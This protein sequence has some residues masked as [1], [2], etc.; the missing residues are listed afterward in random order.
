M[1]TTVDWR[2]RAGAI[3][4]LGV[5]VDG[6][7]P[8][9]QAVARPRRRQSV[10]ADGNVSTAAASSLPRRHSHVG[11]STRCRRPGGTGSVTQSE[12][13]LRRHPG[14][15]AQE[16][17][18]QVKGISRRT[19]STATTIRTGSAGLLLAH[20]DNWIIS[21]GTIIGVLGGHH[22][23]GDPKKDGD[24]SFATR[25]DKDFEKSWLSNSK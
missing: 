4:H 7:V 6:I 15:E 16:G 20:G 11:R 24:A 21:E 5:I 9:E 13:R 10:F 8:A 23:G 2:P 18:H 19:S 14:E 12:L 25:L 22:Q 17:P 3:G 1:W